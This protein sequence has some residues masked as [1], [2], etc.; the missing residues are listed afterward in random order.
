MTSDAFLLAVVLT[1]RYT[2]MEAW[3]AQQAIVQSLRRHR[4]S[5]P[6]S[7]MDQPRG[8][9]GLRGPS[10]TKRVPPTLPTNQALLEGRVDEGAVGVGARSHAVGGGVLL[11][12]ALE[13][14]E[15]SVDRRAVRSL[16]RDLLLRGAVDWAA[17]RRLRAWDDISLRGELWGQRRVRGAH[18]VID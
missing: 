7:Q 15:E 18:R 4:G 1:V 8:P 6:P 2:T 12:A 9:G 16:V 3:S 5:P 17:A 11:H 10:P 14:L 13:E